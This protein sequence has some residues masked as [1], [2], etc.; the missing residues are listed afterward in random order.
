MG[1]EYPRK[2]AS[3][4]TVTGSI[5]DDF[6]MDQANFTF[7]YLCIIEAEISDLALLLM[8]I[9]KDNQTNLKTENGGVV[10]RH[11]KKRRK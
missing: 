7:D 8:S 1:P 3:K 2:E 6:Y 4:T 11:N 9:H 5:I 10:K